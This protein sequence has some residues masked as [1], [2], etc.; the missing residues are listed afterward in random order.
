MIRRPPR[1]TL[2]PYTTLF[3]SPT[4]T[5]DH[6]ARGLLV[7]EIALED[8]GATHQ[9]FALLGNAHL[10][11]AAG[12][13]RRIGIGLAIGLERHQSRR[14]RRAVDLFEIHADGAEEAEGIGA[15]RRATGQR[16]A[17]APKSELISHRGV[18]EQVA[19]RIAETQ[20]ER[21][22]LAVGAED[23]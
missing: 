17:R 22:R 9:H 12:L 20:P 11:A 2:F 14:L 6:F 1:S 16:P 8:A 3:R 21:N 18:H 5:I 19:E 15:E 7:P 10:D 23:L 4:V 13:A